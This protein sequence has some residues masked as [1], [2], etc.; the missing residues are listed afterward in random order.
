MI[1][2]FPEE[3][4]WLTED[5]R[6]FIVKKLAADQGSS[7]LEARITWRS[8]VETF[9]DWKMIPGALMYFGP[10]VS[11]YGEYLPA[12]MVTSIALYHLTYHKQ[13]GLA[14]FIPSIVLTYGYT[15]IQAQLHSV[16]PWA[17]AVVL[18]LSVAYLSDKIKSRFSFIIFGLCLALCGNLVLFTVHDNR[19]VQY[20]AVFLYLMGVISMLPVVVCLFTM[21][22]KGHR[23]RAVG[24]AWQVGFGNCAGIIAT[25]AFPS[26]DAPR[27]RLGYSLGLGFLCL[28]GAAALA[29]FVGCL[30]A[31]KRRGGTDR[32]I[33]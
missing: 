5:E 8:V 20:A 21:N 27:Y 10:A 33:L 1:T 18:S 25:F 6:A 17:A 9:S 26:A 23:N 24:T 16:A 12:A 4:R 7:G 14:Y 15:P 31:N 32:F 30:M 3:A 19:R 2:D 13:T 29:Y 11:A 22:L 28:A